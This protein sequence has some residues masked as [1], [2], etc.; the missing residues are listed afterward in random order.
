MPNVQDLLEKVIDRKLCTLCG[1]CIG[2]CPTVTYIYEEDKIIT[3]RARCNSCGLCVRSCPGAE[4]SYP[5]FNQ[6]IFSCS[7]NS[8]IGSFLDILKGWANKVP[9]RDSGTSGGAVTAVI[10]SLLKKGEIDGALV[11]SKAEDGGYIALV[12]KTED[13]IRQATQSKYQFIPINSLIRSVLQM[14]GKYAIVGLPCH[15]QGLR[16]ASIEVPALED[17]FAYIFGVFCGFNMHKE[18]TEY[19]LKKSKIPAREIKSMEYRGKHNNASGFKVTSKSGKI[20]FLPKHNYTFLNFF[21][22]NTRCMKCFD[23]TAEFADISFGDAWETEN[24]TRIIIRTKRGEKAINIATNELLYIEDSSETDIFK[25][26]NQ[27][28]NHKKKYISHRAQLFKTFPDYKIDFEILSGKNKVKSWLFFITYSICSCRF[29]RLIIRIIPL[30]L[31]GFLSSSIRGIMS[32]ENS[33]LFKYILFGVCT[34]L[35]GIASFF[36]LNIYL[37]FRIAS[38]ISIVMTKLFAY[39][40]N[41]KFVFKSNAKGLRNSVFEFCRFL[42]ARGFTAAIEFFG[43]ILLVQV[44]FVGENLSRVLLILL[45]TTVNYILGRRKVFV[46][47]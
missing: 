28:I 11:A 44:F 47:S 8:R 9:L 16:K 22:C 19:L 42:V 31:L 46:T 29:G 32:G 5:F 6:R 45:T 17:K 36:V 33:F 2:V 3:Q 41:K 14:E 4:Y 21:F 1:T 26:Q 43:L 12:A 7:T 20:F 13:E 24:C 15:V 34:V 35:F 39:Y 10:C 30:K 37:D 38:I 23:F 25:T 40:M 18:A 27:L